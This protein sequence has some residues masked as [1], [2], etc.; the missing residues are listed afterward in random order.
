VGGNPDRG[1]ALVTRT[2]NLFQELDEEFQPADAVPHPRY[3]YLISHPEGGLT[4]VLGSANGYNRFFLPHTGVVNGC[5]CL[6]GVVE[7]DAEHIILDDPDIIVLGPQPRL[8][9]PDEFMNDPRWRGL[10]AVSNHRVYRAP[11]G[12]DYFIAAPFWSRWL[13]E[14]AHPDRLQ[15]KSRDLY[16]SY[17]QWLLD[18]RLSDEELDTAYA[19]KDNHAMA[20]AERFE[21]QNHE[22]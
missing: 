20:N 19:V 22:P 3:F 8:Q 5:S 17:V 16:R 21:A 15:P 6:T 9:R 7:V 4:K 13:A 1:E 14:L 11:P 2:H 10:T 12:I 18:Y